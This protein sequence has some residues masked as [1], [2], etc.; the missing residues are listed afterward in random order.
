ML[1]DPDGTDCAF[2]DGVIPNDHTCTR[3]VCTTVIGELSVCEEI[4]CGN[5]RYDEDTDAGYY[6]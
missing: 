3:W 5:G 2:P 6:E 1:E 4:I